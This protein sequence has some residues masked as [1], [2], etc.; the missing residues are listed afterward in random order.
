[1]CA[2][3]ASRRRVIP[4]GAEGEAEASTKAE[5]EDDHPRGR[6]AHSLGGGT[7]QVAMSRDELDFL[8]FLF[9]LCVL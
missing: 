7:F 8:S 5:P 1:M 3:R 9:M 4:S 2:A 6:G